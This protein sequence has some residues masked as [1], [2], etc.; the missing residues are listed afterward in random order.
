MQL[1]RCNDG[2]WNSVYFIAQSTIQCL[3][4]ILYIHNLLHSEYCTIYC[5]Y[6]NI[7]DS[8]YPLSRDLERY[9]SSSS[10]IT[11][12][13]YNSHG[14]RHYHQHVC[15]CLCTCLGPLGCAICL[16][17]VVDRCRRRHFDLCVSAI[18]HVSIFQ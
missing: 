5:L 13:G 14:I 10:P 16:G 18:R 2:H 11:V 12:S 8:I 15:L 9:D 1:V 6:N 4:D 17:H 7:F 3:M